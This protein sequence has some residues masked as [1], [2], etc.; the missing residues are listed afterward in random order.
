M[1]LGTA[2]SGVA[3]SRLVRVNPKASPTK[4]LPSDLRGMPVSASIVSPTISKLGPTCF[5]PSAQA[6][7]R[8]AS[9]S[10]SVPSPSIAT[11]SR[12][13]FSLLKISGASLSA[14]SICADSST[15][16]RLST[17]SSKT[18][19]K[20]AGKGL[21]VALMVRRPLDVVASAVPVSETDSLK[22]TRGGETFK[23][24][25]AKRSR[26]SA[27][28]RSRCTSPAA[29]M[30]CS[31][32]SMSPTSTN[33][34]ERLSKRSPS[35]SAGMSETFSGSTATFTIG[36]TW[37]IMLPKGGHIL[38][39]D[40][41]ALFNTYFSRPPMARTFPAGTSFTRNIPWPIIR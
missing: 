20:Y 32:V 19:G 30:T 2:L 29:A 39:L 38:V 36:A 3:Y 34:S 9:T 31:P 28:H 7:D 33:A 1:R 8:F 5:G 15:F 16:L 6:S 11:A 41:V 12:E 23:A 37:N 4:G 22:D 21:A 10:P 26:R 13:V 17:E 40:S 35:T 18:R 27:M 24:T 25:F 14:S